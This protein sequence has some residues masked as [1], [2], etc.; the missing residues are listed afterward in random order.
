MFSS[1]ILPTYET[2]EM[3]LKS[4]KVNVT[5]PGLSKLCQLMNSPMSDAFRLKATI[6]HLALWFCV[7]IP[8]WCWRTLSFLHHKCSWSRSQC[9]YG[10]YNLGRVT[11][12]H[13]D[14][15][16]GH[17][18]IDFQRFVFQKLI[19]KKQNKAWSRSTADTCWRV[20]CLKLDRRWVIWRGGLGFDAKV[21][22]DGFGDL[23]S[24]F[25]PIAQ[26]LVSS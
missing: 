7:K 6:V 3:P 1:A 11:Y 18:A 22:H 12:N 5:N 17:D 15:I 21:F 23:G 20:A 13:F 8:A 26:L 25:L 4:L 2:A 14:L 9:R 24:K 16:W 10:C 19:L